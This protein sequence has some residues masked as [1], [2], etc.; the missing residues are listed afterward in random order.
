MVGSYSTDL[1]RQGR[2]A[3]SLAISGRPPSTSPKTG[4][5]APTLNAHRAGAPAG[6][7]DTLEG[8]AQE[9]Q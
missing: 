3:R 4:S 7:G 6:C 1:K 5:L 2:A 9:R 8:D